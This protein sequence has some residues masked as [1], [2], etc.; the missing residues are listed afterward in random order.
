MDCENEKSVQFET[1]LSGPV[2]WPYWKAA[3]A[4]RVLVTL[5]V[6]TVSPAYE[7]KAIRVGTDWKVRLWQPGA[8]STPVA[9]AAVEIGCSGHFSTES[10]YA[11]VSASEADST[12]IDQ[13]WSRSVASIIS[14]F[15]PPL[16]FEPPKLSHQPV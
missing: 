9:L 8:R 3:P 2:I 14:S 5:K 16:T 1:S 6:L 4:V 7:K 10:V 13:V 12:R 15:C 11:P